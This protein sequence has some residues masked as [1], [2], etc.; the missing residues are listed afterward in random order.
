MQPLQLTDDNDEDY[1]NDNVAIDKDD[2]LE[3]DEDLENGQW[4]ADI[5]Y[6]YDTDNDNVPL[7]GEYDV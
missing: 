7:D 6:D 5:D 4:I 3:C 1:D 2:C